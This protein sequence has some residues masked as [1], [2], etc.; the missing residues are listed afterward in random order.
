VPYQTLDVKLTLINNGSAPSGGATLLSALPASAF[1]FY[2][3]S[4]KRR[5]YEIHLAD[6]VPTDKVNRNL[7]GTIDD[8]S[9]GVNYYKTATNL[10]W[11]I[12]IVQGFSYPIEGTPLNEAYPNLIPWAESNG[13]SYPDWFANKPGYRVVSKIY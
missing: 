8:A 7:L 11:G 3:I 10:P 13:V 2:I 4:D 1:N 5:G 6:R 9:N 12:D